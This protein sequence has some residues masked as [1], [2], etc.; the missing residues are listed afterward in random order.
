MRFRFMLVIMADSPNSSLDVSPDSPP[1]SAPVPKWLKSSWSVHYS[2]L[3]LIIILGIALRFWQLDTKA[4]WLDEVIG[5]LFSFGRELGDVPLGEFFDFSALDSLFRLVPA[6]C[7]QITQAVATDSVHP[8]GYFC[9]MHGWL[10]LWQT[11]GENWV[12]VLR[13]LPALLGTAC[14]PALYWLNRQAVSPR[15]GLAGAALMAVSPFAVYLSQEAR[16]YT[17]PMLLTLLTLIGAVTFQHA[18]TQNRVIPWPWLLI[19]VVLSS[20]GMY[21]HYFYILVVI[22]QIVALGTLLVWTS[23]DSC[24]DSGKRRIVQNGVRL[25][26]AIAAL[27]TSYLPWLPTLISHFDRPETDW[28]K[29]Y[30]PDWSDRLAPL[31]QTLSG[32]LLMVVAL[33]IEDQPWPIIIPSAL[34]MVGLGGWVLGQAVW[35]VRCLWRDDRGMRPVLMVLGVFVGWVVLQFFAIT[36]ILDKDVTSV[37]RYNFV[38]YPGMA[39]LIAIGLSHR[40]HRNG[41]RSPLPWQAW[42]KTPLAIA[43]AAGVIS[44]LFVVHGIVFQKGYYPRKVAQDMA[45]EGDRPVMLVVS[46]QSLQEVGLGLSFALELENRYPDSAHSVSPSPVRMAFIE[47]PGGYPQVWRSLSQLKHD[48]T[49]PLNLWVV[50][51]PGMKTEDY[52]TQLKIRTPNRKGRMTCT[53]D[54]SQFNRIGFPYQLFRCPV[55]H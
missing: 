15:A 16:H 34:A 40:L 5:A 4:L 29:P 8:P 13:S 49:P 11:H 10:R 1:S 54:P 38:Y 21:V 46:Y 17:L 9:L 43:L 42:V 33:P 30:N 12:W 25:G 37:P 26:V 35:G 53:I 41:G 20:L 45:F 32:W 28:L 36:Y 7:P 2:I 47:R 44:S 31:Y 48:V 22:A 39:A 24:K 55:L 51:S 3:V 18:I 23:H 52:P 14:I 27:V 19:W 50:A 6:T